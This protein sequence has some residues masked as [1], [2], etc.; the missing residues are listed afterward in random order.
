MNV[1]L[2]RTLRVF[3]KPIFSQFGERGVDESILDTPEGEVPGRNVCVHGKR[4]KLYRNLQRKVAILAKQ[5]AAN[6]C[7]TLY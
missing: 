1:I 3:H 6:D 4:E 2:F 7:S 5:K